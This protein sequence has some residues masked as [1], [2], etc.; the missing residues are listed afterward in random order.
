MSGGKRFNGRL[1]L[2]D[3]EGQRLRFRGTFERL[4]RR[5]NWHGFDEPTI[6]L[7]NVCALDD[8]AAV[9]DHLWFPSTNGFE[10]LGP[11][12]QGD[13]IEFDA[14]VTRYEKGYR[15][16]RADVAAEC[17]PSW[18]FRLSRPTRLV[19]YAATM[20]GESGEEERAALHPADGWDNA[21]V[22]GTD[23]RLDAERPT[24]HEMGE[25]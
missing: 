23:V 22:A 13:V 10:A 7:R 15:G 4:G 9:T 16:W 25:R 8:G 20:P 18:D 6:L 12:A 1:G 14:R 21:I 3:R 19:R 24:A 17:P 5:R 11:L 2:R